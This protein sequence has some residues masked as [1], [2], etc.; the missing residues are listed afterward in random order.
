MLSCHV[1]LQPA[2]APAPNKAL[3][4]P[5]TQSCADS[6]SACGCLC[7]PDTQQLGDGGEARAGVRGRARRLQSSM[8][9][10]AAQTST[11]STATRHG[12]RG[13]PN[14]RLLKRTANM[15]FSPVPL[16]GRPREC[17]GAHGNLFTSFNRICDCAV[18]MHHCTLIQPCSVTDNRRCHAPLRRAANAGT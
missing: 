2:A 16:A 7:V 3:V 13:P 12:E 14:V 4:L 10:T 18:A 15:S 5:D 6:H 8:Q 9:R 17:H 11:C 1:S